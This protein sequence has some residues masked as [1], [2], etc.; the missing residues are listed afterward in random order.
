MM[1][2][3]FLDKL[4]KNVKLTMKM[5]TIFWDTQNRNENYILERREY[6]LL[7]SSFIRIK[8]LLTNEAI[9]IVTCASIS[10]VLH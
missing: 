5:G 2:T 4:R 10:P 6:F 1:G 8:K 3:I 7:S 9:M